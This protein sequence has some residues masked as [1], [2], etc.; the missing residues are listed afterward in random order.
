MTSHS[1]VQIAIECEQNKSKAMA[2]LSKA[3]SQNKG[4]LKIYIDYKTMIEVK[5]K[6]M[7]EKLLDYFYDYGA[8]VNGSMITLTRPKA[9][10]E[11]LASGRFIICFL[12]CEVQ[13]ASVESAKFVLDAAR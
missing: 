3:K 8:K 7:R 5:P 4:K 6:F 13:A 12:D 9:K 10:V 2:A 11:L 1:S